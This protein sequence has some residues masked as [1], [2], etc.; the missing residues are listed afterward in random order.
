MTK[1]TSGEKAF[2]GL[3]FTPICS[4]FSSYQFRTIIGGKVT[5]VPTEYGSRE[6]YQAYLDLSKITSIN[7]FFDSN[8]GQELYWVDANC[9]NI[10]RIYNYNNVQVPSGAKGIKIGS[11]RNA[12][13]RITSFTT[14]DG[15]V[16]TADNLNY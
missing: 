15:K 2:I 10:A 16:H 5:N 4:E 11:A 14:T 8:Y 13:F 7:I 1:L 12:N 9:D 6:V 3:L